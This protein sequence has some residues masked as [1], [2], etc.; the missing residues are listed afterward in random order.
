MPFHYVLAELVARVPQAIGVVFLDDSGETIDLATT[1]YTPDDLRVFGAYFGISL[2]QART[3][4]EPM[5]GEPDLIHVRQ[6][7]VNVHAVYLPD[8]YA[9]VLLQGASG[10]AAIARRCLRSAVTDLERELFS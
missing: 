3:T 4:I 10:S 8:E 1:E 5:L 2:R 6:G 7:E 9:L